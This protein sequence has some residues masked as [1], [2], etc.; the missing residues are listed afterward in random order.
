MNADSRATV[1]PRTTLM[2]V[3]TGTVRPLASTDIR[4][5]IDKAPRRG[6]VRLGPTGFEGDEQGEKEIH[7]GPDKAALHYAAHHYAEWARELP[8]IAGR[9]VPGGFG[10]NLVSAGV[11]ETS[12]CIGDRIRIGGALVEVAQPRQPCFKLN[13]RFQESTMSRRAQNS[14]RT[15][16]YYRVIEP[17]AVQS[18]D[19]IEVIERPHPDWTVRRVQQFLYGRPLDADA[20][21]ELSRL[22]ALSEALRGLFTRRLRS[23]RVENWEER[24]VDH[25][26]VG[27]EGDGGSRAAS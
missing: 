9:C 24:L 11:D 21:I 7:G 20:L 19:P 13:H 18:G 3:C 4:S 2:E 15:G 26:P 8:A 5:A 16:W 22:A 1:L 17:G 6:P 10:E 12:V 25:N 14:G 23:M 27:G